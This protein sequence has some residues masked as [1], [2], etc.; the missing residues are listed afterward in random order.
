MITEVVVLVAPTIVEGSRVAKVERRQVA[1]VYEETVK[2]QADK[3]GMR[4][5]VRTVVGGTVVAPWAKA[6]SCRQEAYVASKICNIL[7]HR[8]TMNVRLPASLAD[9]LVTVVDLATMERRQAW[10]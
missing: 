7:Q 2:R 10:V 3:R 5:R 6:I 9:V 1:A 8:R 4:R